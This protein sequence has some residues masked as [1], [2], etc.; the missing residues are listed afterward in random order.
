MRAIV[1]NAHGGLEVLESA[2]LPQPVP[3][4]CEVLV[5]VRAVAVNPAD[6]KWRAGMFAS[7]APVSFPHILGYDVAGEV[8]D[9]EGFAT[10]DRVF[11]MLDPFRKGGYAEYVTVAAQ[12][13]ALV[14]DGMEFDR[15]AAIP[16]A[17][18]TGTQMVEQ[19]LDVKPGTTILIT[20]AVGAVGRFALHAA[21]ARGAHVVAA[22][23]ASQRKAALAKGADQALALGEEDW[24]GA[25]FDHVIDT[26]GGEAVGRLCLHLRPGGRILSAATTPVTAE[27]LSVQPEFHAVQPDGANAARLAELVAKGAIEVPIAEVLPLE[28]AARAQELTDRGG[29]GGKIILKP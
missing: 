11:G 13:L 12:Q 17:G 5:K 3:G 14:P 21:K 23:C 16:T 22:V 25:P 2:E 9:G 6:G 8:V 19:G 18:L 1:I 15:A 28:Q 20:G 29:A 26:V 27:G 10:G 24:T 7:F 4:P